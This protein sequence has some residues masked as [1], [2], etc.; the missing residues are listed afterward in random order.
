MNQNQVKQKLKAL[1]T[2]AC[3]Q[4]ICDLLQEIDIQI[5]LEPGTPEEY[6]VGAKALIGLL[7]GQYKRCL[8]VESVRVHQVTLEEAIKTV[9]EEDKRAG[10]TTGAMDV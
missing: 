2:S 6:G 9:Y 5:G 10:K 1:N 7:R 8:Q 4:I 3:Q